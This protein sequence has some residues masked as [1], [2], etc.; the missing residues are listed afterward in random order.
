[1]I[2]ITEQPVQP[3]KK[4]SNTKRVPEAWA[5]GLN[6]RSV[7]L[8]RVLQSEEFSAGADGSSLNLLTHVD[9]FFGEI[10]KEFLENYVLCKSGLVVAARLPQPGVELISKAHLGVR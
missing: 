10:G 5:V 1:M 4:P 7:Y 6:L 9:I 8:V 3:A 2:S